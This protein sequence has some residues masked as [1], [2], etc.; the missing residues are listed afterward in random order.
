[1][2]MFITNNRNNKKTLLC[3]TELFKII[4]CSLTHYV[5]LD[6]LGIRIKHSLCMPNKVFIPSRSMKKVVE[7][8]SKIAGENAMNSSN[9]NNN[10]SSMQSANNQNPVMEN[11]ETSLPVES[12]YLVILFRC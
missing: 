2:R 4:H 5:T 12:A 10:N 11:S 9:H 8:A 3:K 6:S 7:N 1:M